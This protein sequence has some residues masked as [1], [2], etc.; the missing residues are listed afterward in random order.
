MLGP[1]YAALLNRLIIKWR[2]AKIMTFYWRSLEFPKETERILEQLT[3]ISFSKLTLIP[4]SFTYIGYMQVISND[5]TSID[6]TV[7]T[8]TWLCSRSL[9][10]QQKY[11]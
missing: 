5:W 3:T 11:D 8:W 6:K 9:I 2:T 10:W 1:T 7:P 4:Q